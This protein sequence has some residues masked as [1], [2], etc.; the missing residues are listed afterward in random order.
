MTWGHDTTKHLAANVEQVWQL[1]GNEELLSRTLLFEGWRFSVDWQ[2]LVGSDGAALID[3]LTDNVDDS[4]E[5]FG[6]DGHLDG[7]ASVLDGLATHETLGGVEGNGAHVVATQVLG[8]LKDE[9]VLGA[10]NFECIH[11]RGKFTFELHV[12]DG[13]DDLGNLS[14]GGAEATYKAKKRQTTW[15]VTCAWIGSFEKR[16]RSE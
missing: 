13:T 11:D 6:A 1:T 7:I 12:D 4:A 8:D 10:L 15:S 2:E 14:S 16:A 9:A 5:S 3:R